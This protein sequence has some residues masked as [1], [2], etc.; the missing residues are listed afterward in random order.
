MYQALSLPNV[1]SLKNLLFLKLEKK[2]KP[3]LNE[4]YLSNFWRKAD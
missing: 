2:N 3:A 1:F 4:N